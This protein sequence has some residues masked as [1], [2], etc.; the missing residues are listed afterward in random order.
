ME[1][2]TLDIIG[3]TI[4]KPDSDSH[5]LLLGNHFGNWHFPIPISIWEG[6]N[7]A[8]QLEAKLSSRPYTYD[9]II[10]ILKAFNVSIEEVNIYKLE[11]KTFLS[12]L[13]CKD[14]SGNVVEIEARVVDAVTLAIKNRS[15]LTI[16]KEILSTTE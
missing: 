7:I 3:I 4:G 8:M 5:A 2:E 11:G 1:K 13:I 16:N 15:L 12:K 10:Y 9:L 6:Q 14:P